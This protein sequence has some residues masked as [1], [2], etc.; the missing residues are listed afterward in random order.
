[1]RDIKKKEVFLFSF[2]AELKVRPRG[3]TCGTH[4]C[5]RAWSFAAVKAEVCLKFCLDYCKISQ[6]RKNIVRQRRRRTLGQ[7]LR[8]TEM[9]GLIFS[10]ISTPCWEDQYLWLSKVEK[11][12]CEVIGFARTWIQATQCLVPAW[13][14]ISNKFRWE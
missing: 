4:L 7:Y 12:I 8:N 9:S 14:N 2:W 1:M 10:A 3:C 6:S 13:Q 11:S 5:L